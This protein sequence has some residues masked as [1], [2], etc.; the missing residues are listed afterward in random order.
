[1]YSIYYIGNIMVKMNAVV[2]EILQKYLLNLS[3]S[4][5]LFTVVKYNTGLCGLE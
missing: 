5:F 3:E 4:R 2:Q 1:M